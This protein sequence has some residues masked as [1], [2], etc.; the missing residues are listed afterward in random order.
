[1]PVRDRC[2]N[3][4]KGG[5]GPARAQLLVSEVARSLI[6]ITPGSG[7][8]EQFFR[9]AGEP[10]PELVLPEAGP[11]D[12]DRIAAAAERTGA[13][14]ILLVVAGRLRALVAVWMGDTSMTAVIRAGE[15]KIEGTLRLADAFPSW[16]R[17]SIFA[18]VER[19]EIT[20][21]PA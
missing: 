20:P 2:G 15:L 5:P 3:G 4:C 16:L 18:N 21:A 12:I 1:V 6:L 19:P 11:L 13:V 10:A 9:Q 14:E 7:A 8:M 17:R